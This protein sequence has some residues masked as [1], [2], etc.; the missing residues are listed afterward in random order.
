MFNYFLCESQFGL[1]SHLFIHS[2]I[3][4]NSR[5]LK[6]FKCKQ[7]DCSRIF[8]SLDSFKKH[9]NSHPLISIKNNI[10]ID[11]ENNIDKY[12]PILTNSTVQCYF[13]VNL[14]RN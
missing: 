2:N 4:H 14:R 3:F 12:P 13:S 7:S 1:S 8:G 5:S 6:E 9:I 11:Q 10:T